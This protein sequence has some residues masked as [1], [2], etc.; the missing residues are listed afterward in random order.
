[1]VSIF[2]FY[3]RGILYFT[4]NYLQTPKTNIFSIILLILLIL[5]IGLNI[6]LYVSNSNKTANKQYDEEEKVITKDIVYNSYLFP[7]PNEWKYEIVDVHNLLLIYDDSEDFGVS[8][9]F[10]NEAD[11]DL[12]IED[13]LATYMKE[14]NFQF[15]SSYK[16]VINNRE[17]YLYKGKYG[18][19]NT[20][21]IFTRIENN[22]MGITKLMFEAEV[23]DVILNN[24]LEMNSTIIRQEPTKIINDKFN[25]TDL[26]QAIISKSNELKESDE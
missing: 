15:T 11:Y 2:L 12:L 14:E 1:M 19:Y 22:V 8:V 21:L 20:Y 13:E 4:Q 6:Y 24:V 10:T 5:S 9:Q 7:V 3:H 25:F 16:K 18:E 23:D 17:M 26:S